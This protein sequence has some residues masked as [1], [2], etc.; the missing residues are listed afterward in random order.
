MFFVTGFKLRERNL[1][2]F[3]FGKFNISIIIKTI[4]AFN[5]EKIYKYKSCKYLFLCVIKDYFSL[6]YWYT[7]INK[8]KNSGL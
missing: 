8:L 1:F 4:V 5:P 3:F 2:L 7:Y 6:L